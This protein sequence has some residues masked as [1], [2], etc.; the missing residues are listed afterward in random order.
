MRT[1]RIKLYKFNELSESAK[2]KAINDWR[3]KNDYDSSFE[4][5]EVSVKAVIKL[6]NLKTGR[7]WDDI[8]TSH[9]DDSILEL[10]GVR[11]YKYLMNNY[12]NDLFTP[13]YLGYKNRKITGRQ[14]IFEVRKDYKGNDYTLIYSKLFKN[15][16]CPLTGIC[17]DNDILQPVYDFLKRPGKTT[18]FED[19]M[20]DIENAISKCYRNNEEWINSDEYISETIEANEYEF[21]KD[22]KLN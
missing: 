13:K 22:G 10:K 1:I 9:I 8:R 3:N 16:D 5:I 17:F 7:T 15:N 18:T 12:Y 21:T 11:L 4:E 19:L 6:F 14:F 2:Q 20:R